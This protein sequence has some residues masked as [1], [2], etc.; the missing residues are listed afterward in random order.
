MFVSGLRNI[1]KHVTTA[2]RHAQ[3][4]V[5]ALPRIGR[6]VLQTNTVRL[7]VSDDNNTDDKS[8]S[9]STYCVV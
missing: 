2:V 8:T 4:F 7:P 5:L 9:N 3:S 1:M 6:W